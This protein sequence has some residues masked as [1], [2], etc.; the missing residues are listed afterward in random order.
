MISTLAG[1]P[2]ITIELVMLSA[3]SR[4][5]PTSR[6]VG[7]PLPFGSPSELPPSPPPPDPPPKPPPAPPPKP[8]LLAVL[9]PFRAEPVLRAAPPPLAPPKFAPVERPPPAALPPPA[10]PPSADPLNAR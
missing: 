4:V 3:T 2:W 9:A 7:A 1:G 6:E 8:P 5:R 10:V